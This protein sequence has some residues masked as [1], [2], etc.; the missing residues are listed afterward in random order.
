MPIESAAN[1]PII[2][3]SP[4]TN[5]AIPLVLFLLIVVL[6]CYI[7]LV[8]VSPESLW[9]NISETAGH[10]RVQVVGSKRACIHP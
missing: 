9:S 8:T 10:K 4:A 1:E 2:M 7:D 5:K 6:L 3:T